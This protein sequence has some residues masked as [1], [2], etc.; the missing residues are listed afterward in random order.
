MVDM[1]NLLVE[2]YFLL[3]YYKLFQIEIN[4]DYLKFD[5]LYKHLV[6]DVNQVFDHL[7]IELLHEQHINPNNKLQILL[8]NKYLLVLM[9]WIIIY[10]L[11]KE[12]EYYSQF[13]LNSSYHMLILQFLSNYLKYYQMYLH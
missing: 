9:Q 3:Y 1:H 6:V 2:I 12:K 13:N 5:F 7:L 8:L 11:K 10:Y 4:L